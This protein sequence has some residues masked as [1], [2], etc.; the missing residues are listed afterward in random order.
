MTAFICLPGI[1]IWPI[2]Y[3]RQ[4]L[5]FLWIAHSIHSHALKTQ[6]YQRTSGYKIF[7]K[8]MEE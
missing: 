4:S 5:G 3:E 1:I 2:K 7:E 6:K 8:A